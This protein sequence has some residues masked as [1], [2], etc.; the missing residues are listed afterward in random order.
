MRKIRKHIE[1]L[2]KSSM[3]W[4]I[5]QD[6]S[7][8][9]LCFPSKWC[10]RNERRNSMLMMCHYPVLD[11]ES[12]SALLPQTSL[13]GENQWCIVISLLFLSGC[14]SP[15]FYSVNTEYKKAL[16]L[17]WVL[18]CFLLVQH[19]DNENMKTLYQH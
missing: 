12:F 19:H 3:R 16:F 7:G 6:I 8:C 13:W 4:S 10:L 15:Q 18:W 14:I 2:A 5:R 17:P 1:M 9:H 11:K